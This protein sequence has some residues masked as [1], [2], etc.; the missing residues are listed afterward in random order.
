LAQPVVVD[1][2]ILFSALL[3]KKSRF[4]EVLL[5][6]GHRFY[7]N[8]LVLTEIFKKKEKI[9]RLSHLSDEEV[10]EL[11]YRLTRVLEFFKE[12]LVTPANRRSAYDLCKGIDEKDAP[13]VAITLE[14]GGLLWTGD[15]TLKRG[16]R[17]RG[18]SSFF[19]PEA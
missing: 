15:G 8:E 1:T 19:E 11:F 2:N 18:F 16:L 5:T 13:H 9:V 12:D 3:R 14:L 4:A 17:A 6:S 10:I 7:V